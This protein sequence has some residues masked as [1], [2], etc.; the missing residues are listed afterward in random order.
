MST[1]AEYKKNYTKDELVRLLIE[2]DE[3]VKTLTARIEKIEAKLHQEIDVKFAEHIANLER[4]NYRQ[5]QYSR[6][7]CVEIVGLPVDLD[8]PALQ[9]KVVEIFAHAG[10][11]VTE[12]DFHAIHRL[13]R[14]PVVIAKCVNR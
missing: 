14:S 2:K 5:E 3:L 8:N 10:V 11:K 9:K 13:R 12:R 7:E 4:S 6:R 1:A